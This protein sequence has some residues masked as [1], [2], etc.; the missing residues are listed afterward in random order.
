MSYDASVHDR[1]SYFSYENKEPFLLS[2]PNV[3]NFNYVNIWG[4]STLLTRVQVDV[5]GFWN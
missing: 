5:S 1:N 2:E 4:N 3:N